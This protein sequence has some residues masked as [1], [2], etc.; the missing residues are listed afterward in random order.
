MFISNQGT[1]GTSLILQKYLVDLQQKQFVMVKGWKLSLWDWGQVGGIHCHYALSTW[2]FE[3]A[4]KGKGKRKKAICVPTLQFWLWCIIQKKFICNLLALITLARLLDKM[5]ICP[6]QFTSN[7]E[8]NWKSFT[9]TSKSQSI[10]EW[11]QWKMCKTSPQKTPD[12]I[13]KNRVSSF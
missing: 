3:P 5:L 12:M 2:R 6:S 9:G 1:E 8:I 10:W 11:I 13:E 7:W 4:W